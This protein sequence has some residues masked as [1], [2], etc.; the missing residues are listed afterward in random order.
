MGGW[1]SEVWGLALDIHN[2][3]LVYSGG[4]DCL[5]K[6]HDMR[7]CGATFTSKHHSMGVCCISPDTTSHHQII[8]GSYDET[9]V[10]WDTRSMR[11]PLQSCSV[12]GGVWRIKRDPNNTHM[13]L[14]GMHSGFHVVELEKFEIIR[15]YTEHKSLAYGVDWLGDTVAATCSFYDNLVTV[16]DTQIN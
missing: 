2:S 13:I 5:L 14:A 11:Q 4:D 15:K 16:W 1:G 8:S 10:M 12:G 9:V 6:C 7:S 3:N